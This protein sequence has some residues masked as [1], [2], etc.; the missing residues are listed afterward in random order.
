MSATL[1]V[2]CL[3]LVTDR[4]LCAD[5]P[6]EEK[7]ARAVAGGVNLVQL[8]EKDLPAAAL[9]ELARRLRL[10]TRG[11]ALLFVNDRVD[12]ALACGAD[13]VQLG[14]DGLPLEA[15][16]ALVGRDLL[17]GR[18]VHTGEGA[19]QA[20][21]Q[22]AELL[23]VGTIFRTA[24]HPGAPPA[25]VGLLRQ[26]AEVVR[27][28]F[29]GIGGIDRGNVNSVLEAGA[30]GVVVIRTILEAADPEREAQRLRGVMEETWARRRVRS[31]S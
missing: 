26:V 21:R 18:S 22:G 15:A 3:A 30:S 29:L 9:L 2:P 12:V 13:G 7:V 27:I 17:L 11:K 10:V 14:E 23:V 4:S 8:R 20:E 16:R 6:L 1:P 31:A 28:P 5:V 25:G 19:S 24:S